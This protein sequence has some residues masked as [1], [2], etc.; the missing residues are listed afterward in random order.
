MQ[1]FFQQFLRLYRPLTNKLN[2]L[3]AE[4]G[5]SYSLWQV[6]FY[7]KNMGPSQLS[8]ISAYFYIERP[9]VTRVVQQLE[10]KGLVEHVP[11]QDKRQKSIQLTEHGVAI[12][13]ACREKISELEHSMLADIPDETLQTAFDLFPEIRQNLIEKEE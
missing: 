6:I 10:E 8:S 5:L 9:S 12:Y 3:L 4:F 1:G 11:G 7:I 2:E 13:H